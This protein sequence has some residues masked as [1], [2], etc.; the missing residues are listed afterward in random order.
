MICSATPRAI[1]IM[2]SVAMKGGSFNWVM[3][4]PL[5]SPQSE[6]VRIPSSMPI[7]IGSCSSFTASAATTPASARTEPTD[8]SIPP[9]MMT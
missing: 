1:S 3:T 7:Q 8:R 6:P 9:V 4:K 2:P 5:I